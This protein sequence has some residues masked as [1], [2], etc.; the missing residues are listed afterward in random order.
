MIFRF[1]LYL[2]KIIIMKSFLLG[3]VLMFSVAAIN[4]QE[5]KPQIYNPSADAKV[6]IQRAVKQAKTD[7]KHVLLQ[8]GGNW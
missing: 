6:E 8:I 2:K 3:I 7:G 4:A 5:E 1:D